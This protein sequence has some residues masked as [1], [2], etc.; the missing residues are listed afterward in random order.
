[1]FGGPVCSVM[2][3][4][5]RKLVL[6]CICRLNREY[7]SVLIV[8]ELSYKLFTCRIKSIFYGDIIEQGFYFVDDSKLTECED[9]SDFQNNTLKRK[10]YTLSYA[11]LFF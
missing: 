11:I 7:E 4:N 2:L 6:E 1:M 8:L 10:L 9:Y 5:E 3:I